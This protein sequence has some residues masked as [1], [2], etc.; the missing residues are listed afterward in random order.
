MH[1]PVT[2][3]RVFVTV[4]ASVVAAF[5]AGFAAMHVSLAQYPDWGDMDLY[6]TLNEL[7]P[8]IEAAAV[9]GFEVQACVFA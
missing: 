4:L 2:Y 9:F 7:E 8:D 6:D 5:F 1:D 3:C